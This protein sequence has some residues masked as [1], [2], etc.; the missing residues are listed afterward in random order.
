MVTQPY[1]FVMSYS[2][3]GLGMPTFENP[4]V[5]S[6]L[7]SSENSTILERKYRS[8]SPLLRNEKEET[9]PNISPE[10]HNE[11]KQVR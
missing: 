10:K 7:V 4:L 8:R 11:G 6:I 9:E 1:T 2:A 3:I 5:P